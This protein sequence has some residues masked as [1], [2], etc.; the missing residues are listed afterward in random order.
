MSLIVRAKAERIGLKQGGEREIKQPPV[1]RSGEKGSRLNVRQNF[2]A[3]G[4]RGKPCPKKSSHIYGAE[5]ICACSGSEED[6]DRD[7]KGSNRNDSEERMG[8]NSAGQKK[9]SSIRRNPV[10]KG[11]N[12]KRRTD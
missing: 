10:L 8:E 2:L 9:A 12:L 11:R 1:R 7:A 5:A 4:E 6:K 3:V